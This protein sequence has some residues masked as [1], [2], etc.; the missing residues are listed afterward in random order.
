MHFLSITQSDAEITPLGHG[1]AGDIHVVGTARLDKVL[2]CLNQ[3]RAGARY[4][5]W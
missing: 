2:G 3:R 5:T 4:G 1:V